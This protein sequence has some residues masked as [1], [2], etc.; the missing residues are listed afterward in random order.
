MHDRLITLPKTLP[1]FSSTR[2]LTPPRLRLYS[3]RVCVFLTSLFLWALTPPLLLRSIKLIHRGQVV[4]DEAR[5]RGL[6]MQG[7]RVTFLSPRLPKLSAR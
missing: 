3:S 1:C 5:L 4:R 6:T 7:A 2:P